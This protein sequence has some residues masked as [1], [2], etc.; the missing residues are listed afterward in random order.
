MAIAVCR[1]GRWINKGEFFGS[2]LETNARRKKLHTT[3]DFLRL[4]KNTDVF[5]QPG[6]LTFLSS[7]PLVEFFTFYSVS[8]VHRTLASVDRADAVKFNLKTMEVLPMKRSTRKTRNEITRRIEATET[9]IV[10]DYK[11]YAFM[12]IFAAIT[13]LL[14]VCCTT[15]NIDLF[16]TCCL[17]AVPFVL[18]IW[19]SL[20]RFEVIV[21]EV[22]CTDN[23]YVRPTLIT[24]FVSANVSTSQFERYMAHK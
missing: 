9:R 4:Q 12:F 16:K 1:D 8:W 17:C 13:V 6:P 19:F 23:T 14:A 2:P 7:S 21:V 15:S 24:D 11:A 18:T 5:T 20:N 22:A 3:A 10:R